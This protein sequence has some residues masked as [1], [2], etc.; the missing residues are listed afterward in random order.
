MISFIIQDQFYLMHLLK[1]LHN[2][3]PA[4]SKAFIKAN[5]ITLLF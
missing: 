5:K 1:Y 4:K 3:L 2:F